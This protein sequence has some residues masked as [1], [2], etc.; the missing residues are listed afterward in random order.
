MASVLDVNDAQA[1]RLQSQQ[2]ILDA[3]RAEVVARGILG[4]RVAALQRV[5]VVPSP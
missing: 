4:M 5:L 1:Q 3:A 2:R